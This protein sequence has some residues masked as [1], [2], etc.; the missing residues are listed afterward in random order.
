MARLARAFGAGP[1]HTGAPDRRDR[2]L[3]RRLKG[4]T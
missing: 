2:R 4:K 1:V 3:L